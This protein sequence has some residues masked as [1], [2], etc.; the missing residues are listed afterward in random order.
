MNDQLL[1]TALNRAIVEEYTTNA[2][3]LIEFA[4]LVATFRDS[5]YINVF[6][7]TNM[8]DFWEV[9]RS[10]SMER[11]VGHMTY[12]FFSYLNGEIEDTGTQTVYTRLASDLSK[13]LC[14]IYVFK[15][16]NDVNVDRLPKESMTTQFLH[17][18]PW[19]MFIL[20]AENNMS[21]IFELLTNVVRKTP[22]PQGTTSR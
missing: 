4:N 18:N 15:D 22:T 17:G 7:R 16:I 1:T 11:R 19:L 3:E 5:Y 12:R 14:N 9:V 2:G 20:V 10:K 8:Q 13:S 6:N 21:N